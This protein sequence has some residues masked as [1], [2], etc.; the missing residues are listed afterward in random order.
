MSSGQPTALPVGSSRT[1]RPM[2]RHPWRVAIVVLGLIAVANLGVLLLNKS[3]TT[4]PAPVGQPAT[5]V[6]VLPSPGSLARPQTTI[7]V[8]L[9]TNLT[10]TLVIDGQEVPLNQLETAVVTGEVAYRPGPGKPLQQFAPG[11]HSVTVEFWLA[12][13]PR[14]TNP[15]S[16]SWTFRVGA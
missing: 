13:K 5:V 7:D 4:A 12:T 9:Q 3:D 15:G 11:N 6:S 8:Q 1:R 14:P 2:F 16:Y 10:G